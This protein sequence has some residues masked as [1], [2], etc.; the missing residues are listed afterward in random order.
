MIQACHYAG[1]RIPTLKVRNRQVDLHRIH[2]HVKSQQGPDV[3]KNYLVTKRKDNSAA[4][5]NEPRMLLRRRQKR[6]DAAL[7]DKSVGAA[8][9]ALQVQSQFR[10]VGPAQHLAL[11]TPTGRIEIVLQQLWNYI[12]GWVLQEA[13]VTTPKNQVCAGFP[14]PAEEE[15]VAFTCSELCKKSLST[16]ALF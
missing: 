5:S 10:A 4:A 11:N 3:I 9:T 6:G 13:A 16:A 2:R 15:K 8:S 14:L 12:Q 7:K 1:Q